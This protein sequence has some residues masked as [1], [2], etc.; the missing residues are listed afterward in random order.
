MRDPATTSINQGLRRETP[1]VRAAEPGEMPRI[2]QLIQTTWPDETCEHYRADHGIGWDQFRVAGVNGSLVGM[3]KIYR[4]E[5]VW[6][7]SSALVGGIGDVVTHPDFRKQGIARRVL[8]DAI[9]HMAASGCEL[10]I[11]FSELSGLYGGFGWVPVP[12]PLYRG[13]LTQ[14]PGAAEPGHRL[15]PFDLATDLDSV[16]AI[17]DAN[18]TGRHGA[19][20]RTREYWEAQLSW[21]REELE[22]FT[23]ACDGETV[24]AY[25]RAR[26][27]RNALQVIECLS[28]D[29][30]RE[31]QV[32]LAVHAAQYARSHGYEGLELALPCDSHA[33]RGLNEKGLEL[34]EHSSSVLM[35]RPIDTASL[36]RKLSLDPSTSSDDLLASMPP[37]HFWGT[38]AY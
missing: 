31:C 18:S 20:L 17:Y 36:A 4:R 16:S 2:V 8:N 23:V 30:S 9:D 38:D 35:L 1:R 10:S 14:F 27:H 24:V 5:I 21:R 29:Q 34:S 37:F 12:Q 32:D 11:L 6:G 3:L 28:R 15:R 13:D 33:V 19:I 25:L 22:A 26:R 7:D